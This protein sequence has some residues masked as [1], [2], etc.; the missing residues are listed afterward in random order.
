MDIMDAETIETGLAQEALGRVARL[1]MDA[2]IGIA[3][4]KDVALLAAR[5]GG[6]RTI[7]AGREEE[8][9]NWLPLDL[10]KLDGAPSGGSRD[11]AELEQTLAR[12]ESGGW[13][14]WRGWIFA[15]SAAGSA[16]ARSS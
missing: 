6:A 8:F 10:L 13:A 5:C 14:N 15:R 9:L 12:W 3:S 1:G 2:A 7:A 11:G 16:L 4:S